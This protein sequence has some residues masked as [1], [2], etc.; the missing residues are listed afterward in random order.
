MVHIEKF[1]T[2]DKEYYRL[3]QNIRDGKKV[4]HKRKYIGDKL[5]SKSKLMMLKENFLE[6]IGKSGT[7]YF[8]KET[9]EKINKK[10][11]E[12]IKELK[13]LNPLEQEKKLEEFMIR[14]T[15]DSSKLSGLDITLRQTFLILKEGIIPSGFKNLRIAKEVENQERGFMFIINYK[16]TFDLRF[17]KN[18]H[19][20]LMSG[21]KDEISGKLRSGLKRDVKIAGTT[22][23]PPKWNVLEKEIKEFFLWY[24]KNSRKLHPLELASLIHL[25]LISLQLFVD[26]NSRLSRLLMNWI[27]W[28]K[29]Y[30]LIDIPIEDLE[31]YYNAL[32]YYQIEKNEK[33]FVKYIA[34]KFL[35][36]S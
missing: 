14:Y 8:S 16:G 2:K 10:K 33:P 3:V 4:L 23:V 35:N 19:K 22:Y 11:E 21:V 36:Q 7:T 13:K 15:Y 1:K 34:S 5:P 9:L 30:P 20:L 32:D 6:E 12:Y 17:I 24:K 31:N 18:L 28:K 29:G 27:L 26:G 25:K